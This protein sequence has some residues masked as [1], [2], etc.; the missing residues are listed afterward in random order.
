MGFIINKDVKT[1]PDTTALVE[2]FRESWK[3]EEE[4]EEEEEK[5]T[6]YWKQKSLNTYQNAINCFICWTC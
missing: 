2:D 6:L 3:G 5:M 1:E 4:E